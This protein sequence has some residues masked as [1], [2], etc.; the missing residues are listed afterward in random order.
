MENKTAIE[1]AV[2]TINSIQAEL[3]AMPTYD[4]RKL[5][6]VEGRIRVELQ[7]MEA[8]VNH[9]GR[10]VYQRV[11]EQRQRLR[12]DNRD[13]IEKITNPVEDRISEILGEKQGESI[14]EVSNG[15]SGASGNPG[16]GNGTDKPRR[17]KRKSDKQASKTA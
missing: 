15:N 4:S 5:N 7:V 6:E 12:G 3:D 9:V 16:D 11:L 13:F 1:K 14:K 2:D 10:E 8:L 17:T